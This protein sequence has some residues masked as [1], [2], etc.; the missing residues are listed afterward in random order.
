MNELAPIILFT[1]NRPEHTRIT[2]E[3]LM[4]NDLADQSTLYIYCDGAKEGAS[5]VQLD[6]IVEVKRVIRSVQWTKEIHI[7]ES[8]K[9][10]GLARNVID[11]VT[12]VVNKHGKIIVL[13]DDLMLSTG[14]LSYMN[15]ALDKYEHDDQVKQISGFLFPIDIEENNEA[16]FLPLTNT[17]GWGTWT[18]SWSEIDLTAPGYEKLKTDKKLRHRFN[19]DGSYDYSNMLLKQMKNENFGSWAILYWWHVFNQNGL[20]LF[21]DYPLVQHNDFD[22]SGTHS[23]SDDHYTKANWRSD[24]T[25]VKYPDEIR[26]HKENYNVF[27]KYIKTY[28]RFS[29]ANFK[30]K[31]KKL[32]KI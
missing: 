14:F 7:V 11:G 17:I 25:I 19:L 31:L 27:K 1:Y 2:L 28:S 6:K 15:T 32:L 21:P 26:A 20:V 10:K 8:E 23:G 22:Y 13:E 5:K 24:Y 16:F 12:E 29:I 3:H 9:N 30:I 4:A 18:K